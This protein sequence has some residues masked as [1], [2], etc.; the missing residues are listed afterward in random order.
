MIESRQ[1]LDEPKKLGE[2]VF[3]LNQERSS[4]LKT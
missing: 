2:A 1:I 4:L 3:L